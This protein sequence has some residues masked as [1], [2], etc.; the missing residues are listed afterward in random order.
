[1]PLADDKQIVLSA[2]LLDVSQLAANKRATQILNHDTK[3]RDSRRTM[4]TCTV[5]TLQAHNTWI[6][7]RQTSIF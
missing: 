5:Y 1:L 7:Q 4:Q 3:I 2:Q 6:L